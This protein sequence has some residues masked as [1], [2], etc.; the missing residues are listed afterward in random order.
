MIFLISKDI[1][2]NIYLF[3]VPMNGDFMPLIVVETSFWR[4]NKFF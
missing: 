3:N 2:I 4:F 1:F